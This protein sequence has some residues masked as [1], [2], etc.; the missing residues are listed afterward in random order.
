MKIMKYILSIL[1]I[2]LLAGLFSFTPVEK[3]QLLSTKL[4]V[5]V[6]NSLGNPVEGAT[7]SVYANEEAYR[8]S[9]G[10]V[11]QGVTDEKGRV[12]FKDLKT[13]SYYL[14]A[15][16]DDLNNNGEGV[17]TDPLEAGKLNQVNTIIQ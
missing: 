13:E 15:R 17:K 8:N 11:A 9:V 5:T 1:T 12:T 10:H 4:R 6:L 7:V 16:K 14:D 2:L 3:D